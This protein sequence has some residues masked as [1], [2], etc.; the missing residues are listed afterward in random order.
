MPTAS[1][2]W[3]EEVYEAM[4]LPRELVH[5]AAFAA[6]RTAAAHRVLLLFYA[7]RQMER[8]RRPGSREKVWACTNNGQITFTYKEAQEKH[9]LTA[10][11]F[12]SALDEIIRVGFIDIAHSGYGLRKDSTLYAISGRWEHYGTDRFRPAGRPK[13]TQ[14]IGF[15]ERNQHGTNASDKNSQVLCATV[16]NCYA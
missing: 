1:Q 2:D 5:S 15:T 10:S 4:Y 16:D 7:R 3:Q 13:Q 8:R 9:G 11:R 12:R 14:K 6:L